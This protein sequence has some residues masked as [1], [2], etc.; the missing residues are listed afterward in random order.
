V[1][2]VGVDKPIVVYVENSVSNPALEVKVSNAD[3]VKSQYNMYTIRPKRPGYCYVD[4]K[5]R[6]SKAI[7]TFRVKKL[8]LPEPYLLDT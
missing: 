3:I 8:P 5:D 2:Y 1:L 7:F 6:K 4:V